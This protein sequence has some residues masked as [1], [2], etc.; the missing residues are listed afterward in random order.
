MSNY[1][2]HNLFDQTMSSKFERVEELL[3]LDSTGHLRRLHERLLELGLRTHMP[4]NSKTLFFE[5]SDGMGNKH[6]LAAMRTGYISVF[7]FPRT[8]WEQRRTELMHAISGIG[9]RHFIETQGAVSESQYS[10][11][12]VRV[13]DDTANE[14]LQ[15]ING[16]ITQHIT[17]LARHT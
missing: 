14:L 4:S 11:K 9:A 8:Y 7:S 15:V 6:G 17:I 12:Q 3:N 1:K 13:S 5:F 10:F 16:L 2:R